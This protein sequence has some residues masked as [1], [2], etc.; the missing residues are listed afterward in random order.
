MNSTDIRSFCGLVQQFQSFSPRLTELL[1]PIRA[2]FS[3]KSEFT[4][5]APHQEAFEQVTRELASP[6][7]LANFMPSRTWAW[8]PMP[9]SQKG[10][11]M[12]LWQQEPSGDWRLLQ[13]GSR[14]VNA[15]ESRYSATELE[16][17][18]VVWA[19][20]KAHLYLAGSD[21]ELLV[22][23]RPLIPLLNS[24]TLDEM[25][26]QRLTRLKEKLSLY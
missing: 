2:L 21:F 23:Q 14:H 5:E 25:P 9:L 3:L 20:Q 18:A 22:D 6:R 19:T 17:L 10:L 1:A 15:G 24:K 16:L 26:S 12:A 11:G 4:W 8:K 7:V 13:Y